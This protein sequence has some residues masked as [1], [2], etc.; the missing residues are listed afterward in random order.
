M[1][2]T[3]LQRT[4]NELAKQDPLWAVLTDDSKKGNR[5]DP[6][7]F[8]QTGRDEIAALMDDLAAF[9]PDL[10]RADALD[11]GCGVGRLTLALAPHFDRV[12]GI[13]IAPAMLELAGAYNPWGDRVRFLV[14]ASPDLRVL[15]S[16]RFDLVY[17]RFV[18]QHMPS[19]VAA[20]YLPELVRVLRPGGVLVFQLPS[21]AEPP[22][23]GHP[24]KRRVPLPV[25]RAYR[26]IKQRLRTFPRMEEHGLD[27]DRV[28]GILARAGG[29]VVRVVDD[30][31]H[32]AATAGFKYFVRK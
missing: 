3:G 5:W 25:V 19:R 7:Q 29:D 30:R 14:N 27:R 18:L 20:G 28:L 32:G 26:R 4:W 10:R 13:D 6:E 12:V 17:S 2:L 31:G 21:G 11:F 8:F 1:N 24:L 9:A 22:V 16:G 23:T 15:D